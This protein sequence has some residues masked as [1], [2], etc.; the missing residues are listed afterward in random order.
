MGVMNLTPDSFSDGGNLNT[1]KKV[2]DTFLQMLNWANVVD[3]GAEST[4]PFNDS[5]DLITEF[6]RFEINFFP[7]LQKLKDPKIKVSIDTYKPELF[8]EIYHVF[9]YFWPET[10][11]IFND[12]SGKIDAPKTPKPLG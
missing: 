1:L 6:K 9:K 3:L 5:I 7:I 10:K 2:E 4:A 8:Y 12:V 11:L